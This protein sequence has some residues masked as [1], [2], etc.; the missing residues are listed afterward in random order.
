VFAAST[1]SR[2]LVV[3]TPDEEEVEDEIKLAF[4]RLEEPEFI[5]DPGVKRELSQ[6]I[7]ETFHQQSRIRRKRDTTLNMIPEPSIKS[8]YSLSGRKG[9]CA[10]ALYTKYKELDPAT[11]FRIVR[12]YQ[13]T[14]SSHIVGFSSWE[15]VEMLDHT[16]I[17]RRTSDGEMNSLRLRAELQTR[18]NDQQALERTPKWLPL[19]LSCGEKV[20]RLL[21]TISMADAPRTRKLNVR[22]RQLQE[23]IHPRLLPR[24]EF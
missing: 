16:D 22:Y 4:E 3:R 5:I 7:G 10:V 24:L 11:R 18:I 12:D 14:F 8:C 13:S 20:Q 6:F 17:F 1:L 21:S 23:Q 15:M 19:S 9:G 2:A